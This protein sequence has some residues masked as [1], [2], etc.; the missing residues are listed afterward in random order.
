MKIILHIIYIIWFYIKFIWFYI[1]NKYFS[2]NKTIKN[3]KKYDD[4]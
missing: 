1:Y 4:L 3:N 2:Y